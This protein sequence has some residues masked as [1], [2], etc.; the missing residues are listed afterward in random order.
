MYMVPALER[1]SDETIDAAIL[2][3]REESWCG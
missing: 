3:L 1:K 2:A